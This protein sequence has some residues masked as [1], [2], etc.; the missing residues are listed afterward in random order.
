[1]NA[2]VL[3]MGDHIF[4][5]KPAGEVHETSGGYT[6]EVDL[7]K[8]NVHGKGKEADADGKEAPEHIQEKVN[9]SSQ[10]CDN[11]R[12]IIDHTSIKLNEKCQIKIFEKEI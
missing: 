1:M 3:H 11:H 7:E 12:V 8:M 10:I 9:S 5:M 6:V 4:D 2:G